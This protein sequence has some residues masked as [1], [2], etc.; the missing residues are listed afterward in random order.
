[1]PWSAAFFDARTKSTSR[2]DAPA[3]NGCKRRD[4][5]RRT[6]AAAFMFSLCDAAPTGL[7]PL[8]PMG[9]GMKLEKGA[10]PWTSCS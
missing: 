8:R 9:V 1:M 5:I 3:P 2:A 7:D 4:L 6:K 10:E